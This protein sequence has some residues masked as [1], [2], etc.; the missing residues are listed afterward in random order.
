MNQKLRVLVTYSRR[1]GSVLDIAP[2]SNC[3]RLVPRES[4]N[5]RLHADFQRVGGALR[6]GIDTFKKETSRDGTP[7]SSQA[8]G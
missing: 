4:F 1:V 6:H 7:K 3:A 8:A 2:T 5:E